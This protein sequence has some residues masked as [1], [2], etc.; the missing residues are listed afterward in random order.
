MK[1][2]LLIFITLFLIFGTSLYAKNNVIDSQPEILFK[3]DKLKKNQET[4]RLQ[5]EFNKAILLLEK[6]EYE[7]AIIILKETSSILKIPSFLNIGIAYYKLNQIENALLYLNNIYE[8]KESA[9]S[10]T[11]SYISACFY[12]YQIKKREGLSRNNSRCYEEI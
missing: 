1:R 5:V 7:K 8:F 10:N 9:F 3:Y 2:A 11:Y 6:G 4:F 12:L